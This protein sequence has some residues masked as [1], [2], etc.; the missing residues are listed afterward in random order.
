MRCRNRALCAI[1]AIFLWG[2]W[3]LCVQ[4]A[5]GDSVSCRVVS[6]HDEPVWADALELDVNLLAQAYGF[7]DGGAIRA[8]NK[9]GQEIPLLPVGDGLKAMRLYLELKPLERLDF[10]LRPADSW[11]PTD[12]MVRAN[13]DGE[14]GECEIS[15]G[16]VRVVY[17]AGGFDVLYDDPWGRGGEARELLN[18]VHYAGWL[19]DQ[20]RGSVEKPEE[21]GLTRV[22]TRSARIVE[23][24]AD[25]EGDRPVLRLVRSFPGKGEQVRLI[26]TLSLEPGRPI[27]RYEL[28]FFNDGSAPV[29]IAWADGSIQGKF[30]DA[31][32]FLK[33]PYRGGRLH[34]LSE[35]AVAVAAKWLHV[36]P[37][38]TWSAA[39]SGTGSG[40]GF[41]TLEPLIQEHYHNKTWWR[42]DGNG[43]GL[44]QV[45]TRSGFS[46]KRAGYP[47]I[48]IDPGESEEMGAYLLATLPKTDV[49]RQ[50]GLF[51]NALDSRQEARFEKPYALFFGRH[52]LVGAKVESFREDFSSTERWSPERGQMIPS[53]KGIRL[54]AVTGQAHFRTALEIDFSKRYLL[55]AEVAGVDLG[56]LQVIA[57]P[58][59]SGKMPVV[60]VEANEA[61]TYVVD[62]SREMAVKD[63][64]SFSLDLFVK[65]HSGGSVTLTNLSIEPAP[66]EAPQLIAPAADFELTDVAASFNWLALEFVKEYELQ[67]SRDDGFTSPT[68]HRVTA[69]M[70]EVMFRPD[71]LPASGEWFW[72]VRG[73]GADGQSGEWSE[74][75]R[76]VVNDDHSRRPVV[77]KISPARPLF[78]L[79][80]YHAYE[81]GAF[82]ESVPE[83]VRPYTAIVTR[84]RYKFSRRSLMEHV[85]PVLSQENSWMLRTHGPGKADEWSSLAEV[86]WVFQNCPQ[87][88]GISAPE[89][90]WGFFYRPEYK[91]Y[92]TRLIMLCAKYGRLYVWG[93]GNGTTFK[94]QQVASDPYWAPFLRA[95][96]E[97]ITL[98]QKNNVNKTM[99][100]SQGALLGMWLS[101]MASSLGSWCEVWY[102]ND[103]G[104]AKLG[105][106]VGA[107][108]GPIALFP[109][110]FYN[111]SFMHGLAQGATVFCVD[112]QSTTGDSS[113][114]IW[115]NKGETTE[116][117]N[118]YVVP[119]MRGAIGHRVVPSKE[120]VLERIELAVRQP[121]R[122]ENIPHKGEYGIYR[123]LYEAT[124]GFRE[125]GEVYEYIPNTARYYFIPLLPY[126][127]D[128]LGKGIETVDLGELTSV[129]KV[130][131]VFDPA[132]EKS[133][134]GDA[135]VNVVG[136][137]ILV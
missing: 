72:R 73:V 19:D 57:R 111:I 85:Q 98:A 89:N 61:G 70:E 26:E 110:I 5:L 115:N 55:R 4:P 24:R 33:E 97:Y 128:G 86:E 95:Y 122:F 51:F 78:T 126:G 71:D 130:R 29:Y 129:E 127:V 44:A 134:E 118:R 82:A 84:N 17:G 123:R 12:R 100:T 1:A 58:L 8:V 107:K 27:V 87:V 108:S 59:S 77:R 114:A 60:L 66:P 137:S 69:T 75:R 64:A 81:L 93:D 13:W 113:A 125:H 6:F 31:K 124:Y 56:A 67:I 3:V 35:G 47:P 48:R 96:S 39:W 21:L 25:S 105:E 9:W 37:Q 79:E 14:K 92:V 116:T 74:A 76:V 36:P 104:F 133:Y 62:I 34:D 52:P 112:G 68:A 88:I 102:W 65:G 103:A 18:G 80:A 32:E 16:V 119:F 23:G 7:R 30:S 28:E 42:F 43:F 99:H 101:G 63:T 91:P 10:E 132:Y 131:S 38:R 50:T 49:Y 106:F 40:L 45:G 54:V 83:D 121:E 94:W 15:N 117:F 2:G 120:S 22:D 135:F 20:D 90:L 41:T 11:M 136:D 46:D 109:R 53:D